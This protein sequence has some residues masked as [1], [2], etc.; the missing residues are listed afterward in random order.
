MTGGRR[1]AWLGATCTACALLASCNALDPARLLPR[2]EGSYESSPPLLDAA[3]AP[4][5]DADIDEAGLSDA[6]PS[7]G[8]IDAASNRDAGAVSEG[9]ED[10]S[11][12]AMSGDSAVDG[13]DDGGGHCASASTTD[14]CLELT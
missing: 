3:T 7:D 8:H 12:D 14:Y 6:A 5:R 2:P 4:R 11:G 10:A 13:G 9:G 1:Y